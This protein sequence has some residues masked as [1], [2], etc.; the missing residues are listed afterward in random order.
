[1]NQQKPNELFACMREELAVLDAHDRVC[2]FAGRS[3]KKVLIDYIEQD[4][5]EIPRLLVLS[6]NTVSHLQLKKSQNPLF[7]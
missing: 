2:A 5:L 4:R 7:A 6:T 1:M 3:V